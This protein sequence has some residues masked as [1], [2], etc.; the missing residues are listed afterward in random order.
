M[1][2]QEVFGVTLGPFGLAIRHFWDGPWGWASWA[3]SEGEEQVPASRTLTFLVNLQ[4]P[5]LSGIHSYNG[6]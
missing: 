5:H 3:C 4:H 1:I 2:F 6:Y